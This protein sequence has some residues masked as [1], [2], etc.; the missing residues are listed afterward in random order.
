MKKVLHVW[1]KFQSS[2]TL[3]LRGPTSKLYRFVQL[4]SGTHG[5]SADCLLS[6]W[7]HCSSA[8]YILLTVCCLIGSQDDDYLSQSQPG[9]LSVSSSFFLSKWELPVV[10]TIESLCAILISHIGSIFLQ[11]QHGRCS[12]VSR[13]CVG[14]H[15]LQSYLQESFFVQGLE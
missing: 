11:T 2:C 3:V 8:F 10:R 12:C 14:K 4:W 9:S 7:P 6:L 15:H 5:F 1:I 13:L